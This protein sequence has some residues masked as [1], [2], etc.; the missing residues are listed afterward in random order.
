MRV[1]LGPKTGI[2]L[3]QFRAHWRS[4]GVANASCYDADAGFYDA[5]GEAIPVPS[6]VRARLFDD[7][8]QFLSARHIVPLLK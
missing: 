4:F 3:R 8:S 7:H 5:T 6:F 1:R 2:R